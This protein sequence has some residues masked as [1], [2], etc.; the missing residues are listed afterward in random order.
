VIPGEEGNNKIFGEKV[1]GL[2]GT[3]VSL[4]VKTKTVI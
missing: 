4:S 3:K 1:A 2:E